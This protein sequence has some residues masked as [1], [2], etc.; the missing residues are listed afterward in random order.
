MSDASKDLREILQPLIDHQNLRSEIVEPGDSYWYHRPL[1]NFP[2]KTIQQPGD[3]DGGGYLSLGITQTGL[4][5]AEQRALVQR[6]C[7]LL[8]TLGDVRVLWFQSRVTQEMFEAACSMPSLEGLYIKWSGIED[9]SPLAG[10]RNLSHFHL[11]GAPSAGPMETL[12]SL[13]K[14]VDLEIRKVRAAG[15]L[16]FLR[17]LPQLRALSL[18]GDSNSSKPLKIDT[19]TPI[20]DLSQLERLV[21]STVQVQ[22]GLLSP[23]ARLLKL[24]HLF[25]ANRFPMEECA[26]LAGRRPD[27]LCDLFEPAAGP[28]NWLKCKTC[29]Q[30]SMH[31]LT[32]KGK[33]FLCE[34]CD[35]A[36]L[37]KHIAE[38]RMI[39]LAAATA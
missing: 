39:A 36:R 33:P 23:L 28:T 31:M 5:P 14:L 15:D 11:G 20:A 12:C 16:A 26:R 3:Y 29:K 2:P 8:P 10:L 18:S 21:L 4:K 22:D 37:A 24:R 1:R 13:P 17:G 38:F 19:L 9:L 6:W 32:G 25:L 7:A 30:K 35:A 27:I 34:T